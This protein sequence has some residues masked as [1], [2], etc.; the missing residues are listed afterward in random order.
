MN[1]VFATHVPVVAFAEERADVVIDHRVG[2]FSG[3]LD[4]GQAILTK[5]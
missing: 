4:V 2:I 5:R 1:G 3:A